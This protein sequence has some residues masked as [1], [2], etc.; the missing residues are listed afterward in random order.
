MGEPTF[1]LATNNNTKVRQVPLLYGF[2]DFM[3]VDKEDV[4][5]ADIAQGIRVTDTAMVWHC[6]KVFCSKQ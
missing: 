5:S 3:P 4:F 6:T 1:I 2:C